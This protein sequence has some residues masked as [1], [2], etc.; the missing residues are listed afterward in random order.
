LH[1]LVTVRLNTLFSFS[2]DFAAIGVAA[3]ITKAYFYEL[4]EYLFQ[5]LLPVISEKELCR[6]N[7]LARISK[8]LIV[9]GV[10]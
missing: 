6:S 2:E 1:D 7:S 3:D 10:I 5:I 9:E 8:S 4:T